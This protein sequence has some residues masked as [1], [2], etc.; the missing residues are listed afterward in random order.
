MEE[1]NNTTM[2]VMDEIEDTQVTDMV[3]VSTDY[4]EDETE[5]TELSKADVA[6]GLGILAL[7]GAGAV[8]LGTLAVKGIK[9]VVTKV[10]AKKESKET[11]SAEQVD[12]QAPTG[13]VVDGD[14][15]DVTPEGES[16]SEETTETK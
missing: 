4:V 15:E 6:I 14:F 10:K 13:P 1:M 5:E 11:V 16:D 2:E 3:P 8:A 7:A 12:T 9:K